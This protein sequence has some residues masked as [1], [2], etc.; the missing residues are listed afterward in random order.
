MVSG[1]CNRTVAVSSGY[2]T[3][4]L[5]VDKAAPATKPEMDSSKAVMDVV[6]A[7]V[8]ALVGASKLVPSMA[9]LVV[10][11]AVLVV[12]DIFEVVVAAKAADDDAEASRGAANIDLRKFVRDQPWGGVA[13]YSP[14]DGPIPSVSG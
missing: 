9:L 2:F 4:V 7:E 1:I 6:A 10:V 3:N 12:V 11:V 14:S 8:V 5:V 13:V